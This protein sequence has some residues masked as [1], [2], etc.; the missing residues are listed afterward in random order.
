MYD[1]QQTKRSVCKMPDG[2]SIM[3]LN[4][5]ASLSGGYSSASQIAR[6]LT[7]QCVS[8][9]MF[10]P[11]CGNAN[12]NHFN[13]NRP[14]ADFYCP[15]CGSQYELKSKNGKSIDVV[16]DGSYSAMIDRILSSDNP[17]FFFMLYAKSNW[18]VNDFFFVPKHFF[19]PKIIQMRKPL[20]PDARRAGWVGCNI[21][22][23]S[24]PA[25]GRIPIIKNGKEVDKQYVLQ[26]V[27][28]ADSLYIKD[29]NARG[30]LF[31]VLSCVEEVSEP[32]FA[33]SDIY[34]FERKLSMLH[35]NNH[36]VMAKIR[37]Q[38]QLLRDRGIIEFTKRGEYRKIL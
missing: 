13:N 15:E 31:D 4:M 38:L 14:V 27:S 30:W 18:S 32:A 37:Q 7:E 25:T 21:L 1:D 11:R 36:N 34:R 28:V 35:P 3:N 23:N 6:V 29:M 22:V 17:D 26:K 2:T 5:N 33:L 20:S 9:N 16:N 10:C 8:D 12:I 24:I 19:T